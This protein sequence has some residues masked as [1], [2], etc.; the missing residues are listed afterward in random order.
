MCSINLCSRASIVVRM[1]TSAALYSYLVSKV[2]RASNVSAI[3]KEYCSWRSFD[4]MLEFVTK[5]GASKTS[6]AI[7]TWLLIGIRFQCKPDSSGRWPQHSWR[8]SMFQIQIPPCKEDNLCRICRWFL[9]FEPIFSRTVNYNLSLQ[10][11]I[12]KK[13]CE[14]CYVYKFIHDSNIFPLQNQ[15]HVNL[16]LR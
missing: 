4:D 16:G 13:A 11:L 15:I 2:L 1:F 12:V 5:S 8:K 14:I 3:C 9:V 10:Q 6:S 7:S